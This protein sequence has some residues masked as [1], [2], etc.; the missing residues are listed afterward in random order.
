MEKDEINLE[1]VYGECIQHTFNDADA[2]DNP[3]AKVNKNPKEAVQGQAGAV[4]EQQTIKHPHPSN[5]NGNKPVDKMERIEHVVEAMEHN[6]NNAGDGQGVIEE[7]EIDS[8]DSDD[9]NETEEDTVNIISPNANLSW[10]GDDDD[11]E[12]YHEQ[13]ELFDLDANFVDVD[14]AD[15]QH[16]YTKKGK[17]NE[18]AHETNEWELIN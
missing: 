12:S 11:Q 18:I 2:A 6:Y 14:V 1:T 16:E 5:N 13:K 9:E 17:L 3:A 8:G 10:F 15:D 7:E 4:Y